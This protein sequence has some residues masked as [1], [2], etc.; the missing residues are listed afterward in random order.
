ML[1]S[2]TTLSSWAPLDRLQRG[3]VHNLHPDGGPALGAQHV[4]RKV[5]AGEIA[6][7]PPVRVLGT[8][9]AALLIASEAPGSQSGYAT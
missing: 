1:P 7:A 2:S 3:S 9:L 4:A 8:E 5:L 6:A